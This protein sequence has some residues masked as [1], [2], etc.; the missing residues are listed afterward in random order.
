MV[1]NQPQRLRTIRDL[2]VVVA[3]NNDGILRDNIKRSPMVCE[4]G[5]PLHVE[6]HA[7]SASI[8]YN[9]GLDATDAEIV[10]FAH[11]DV[12]LPKGWD[13]LLLARIA[14]LEQR[15]P[16]WGLLGSY[17]YGLTDTFYGPVWSSSIGHILGRVPT[18]PVEVQSYDEHL[19]VMRRASGLR[20]DEALPGFHLYGTDIVQ[21]ARAAGHSAYVMALPLIHNDG[22]KDQLG[23]DYIAGYRFMQK[24]WRAKL[25]LWTSVAKLS[26]HGLHLARVRRINAKT[27]DVRQE[28]ALPMATDPRVYADLCGWT[29]LTQRFGAAAGQ[30]DEAPPHARQ[31]VQGQ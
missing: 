22:Y 31:K 8:A 27:Q 2:T 7:P 20:F 4:A 3:C 24:K 15:D 29:D 19:I 30:C 12:Y 26:W 11:Q 13:G 9:R 1:T 23:D 6:W 10:I 17:G 5:V 21:I 28:R 18:E 25:P 14:E 16:N